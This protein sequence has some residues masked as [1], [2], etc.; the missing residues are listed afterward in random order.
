MNT[1]RSNRDHETATID[2]EEDRSDR[3]CTEAKERGEQETDEDRTF[4]RT[5]SAR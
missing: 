5:N 1:K 4:G 3:G 2:L